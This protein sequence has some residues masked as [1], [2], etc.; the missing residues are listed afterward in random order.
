MSAFARLPCVSWTISTASLL[1][2]R[3]TS[4]LAQ[5]SIDS[6][7]TACTR[8][9]TRTSTRPTS[10]RCGRSRITSSSSSRGGP[11]SSQSRGSLPLISGVTARS[12]WSPHWLGGTGSESRLAS[13]QATSERATTSA[14]PS[15]RKRPPT[16]LGTRRPAKRTTTTNRY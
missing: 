11:S 13:T 6:L 3:T 5:H 10:G 8:F 2:H 4:S 1:F 7:E 9:F 16:S 12:P 15:S 14:S